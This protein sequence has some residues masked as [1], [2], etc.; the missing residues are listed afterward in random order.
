VEL[1][2]ISF[3]DSYILNNLVCQ[4]YVSQNYVFIKSSQYMRDRGIALDE[5]L[6]R[7][8]SLKMI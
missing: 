1:I 6:I 4:P 2:K 3:S 8:Y 7:K 5:G